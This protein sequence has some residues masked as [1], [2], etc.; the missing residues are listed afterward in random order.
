MWKDLLNDANY[1]GMLSELYRRALKQSGYRFTPPLITEARWAT[2]GYT[3][4]ALVTF[5][6]GWVYGYGI[7]VKGPKDKYNEMEGVNQAV[8][9]ALDNGLIVLKQKENH[10]S[11]C[12]RAGIDLSAPKRNMTANEIADWLHR[13]GISKEDFAQAVDHRAA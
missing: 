10:D 1:S 7:T 11:A 2:D 13:L 5:G 8:R 4:L 9:N 12:E 3:T 6:R